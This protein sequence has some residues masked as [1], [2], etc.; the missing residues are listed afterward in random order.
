MYI[1]QILL[2]FE[3]DRNEDGKYIE[4]WNMES[5]IKKISVIISTKRKKLILI[6][7]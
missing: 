5:E 2:E 6:Q 4:T 7:N 3:K 1:K